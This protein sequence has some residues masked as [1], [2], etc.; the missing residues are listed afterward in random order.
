MTTDGLLICVIPYH[1]P[2]FRENQT[3]SKKM[4]DKC[5]VYFMPQE[6]LRSGFINIELDE[7]VR[8]NGVSCYSPATLSTSPAGGRPSRRLTFDWKIKY[9]KSRFPTTN[10]DRI[11]SLQLETASLQF[12]LLDVN[13]CYKRDTS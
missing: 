1:V 11:L 13:L 3:I 12:G 6:T 4:L 5:D 10:S 7:I 2:S 9:D 8:N